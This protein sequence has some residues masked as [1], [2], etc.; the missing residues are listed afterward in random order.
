M[1]PREA[2]TVVPLR[3]AA[4]VGEATQ[5]R[6]VPLPPPALPRAR[7]P[8]WPLLAA[9]AIVAGVGAVGLG[10]WS[11]VTE[12]RSE[13][14][15]DA[16]VDDG[17]LLAV[18]ADSSADRFPLRGSVGRI[19]LVV[20]DD[21]A[22][23]IALDGLGP[24]PAGKSYRVWIV[25]KGSATPVADAAFDGRSRVVGLERRVPR[26]TRVAVTLEPAGD[27]VRPTRPLR[28]STVRA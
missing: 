17:P 9:L 28:L 18:L 2:A 22:A 11:V 19:A 6:P 13:R 24:A 4:D 10:A 20:R 12:A 25:R 15:A 23:V 3:R 26:G 16:A 21:G 1:T 5:A 8:G 14:S 27:A 7:R